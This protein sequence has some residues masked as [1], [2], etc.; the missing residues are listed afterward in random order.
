MAGSYD[1]QG[2]R[3]PNWKDGLCSCETV[4]D[5]LS[6]PVWV[7]DMLRRRLLDYSKV[8]RETECW[9]WTKSVFKKNGRARASLGTRSVLAARLAYVLWNGRIGDK[10]AMHTCDNPLCINPDHLVAG[11]YAE[12]SA[13]MVAKGRAACGD[14]NGSRLYP[15]RLV[16]GDDHPVR[17][18]PERVRGENNGRAMLTESDVREIRRRYIPY[19]S[20]QRPSNRREL[21]EEFGVGV[22]MISL[23]VKG[24]S[25]KHVK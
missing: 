6:L 13:D 18:N 3:N 9:N 20:P 7:Q 1:R 24:K 23:I 5:V 16:R 15:E 14:R 2:C 22:A 17:K 25:W 4:D 21:A 12:N 8:D 10:L 11:T 19:K